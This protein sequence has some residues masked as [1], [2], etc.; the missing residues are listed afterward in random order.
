MSISRAALQ[1]PKS[2]TWDRFSGYGGPTQQ[3]ATWQHSGKHYGLKEVI[4]MG[5]KHRERRQDVGK[6][7]HCA[8]WASAPSIS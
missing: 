6:C 2:V 4:P 5:Q 1:H 7:R 3:A 8:I